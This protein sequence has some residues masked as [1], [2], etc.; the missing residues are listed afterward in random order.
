MDAIGSNIVVNTRSGDVL[1]IVPRLNEVS[2][3]N[4]LFKFKKNLK[5]KKEV[6]EEWLGD[7]SRFAYDG[8]K[9]QRLVSPLIK[10]QNGAFEVCDWED[11]LAIIAEKLSNTPGSQ[12]AAVAG[13]FCDAESLVS[14][15]DFLNRLGSENV[16]TEEVFPMDGAG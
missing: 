15:K 16:C 12:V 8:L 5:Q 11:A 4:L 1:R 14:L 13:G 2:K 9:R 6:N 7:K 10:G 3:V